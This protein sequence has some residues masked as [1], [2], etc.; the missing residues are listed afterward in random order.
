[1]DLPLQLNCKAPKQLLQIIL[2]TILEQKEWE[3]GLHSLQT[4]LK[5]VLD[6]PLQ[7]RTIAL[8]RVNK[9]PQLMYVSA[10]PHQSSLVWREDVSIQAIHWAKQITTYTDEL[11]VSLENSQRCVEILQ[12]LEVQAT[13]SGFL[14]FEFHDRAIAQWLKSLMCELIAPLN[15]IDNCSELNQPEFEKR[16]FSIQQAHARCCSL[17][18]LAHRENL[19]ESYLSDEPQDFLQQLPNLL[20]PEENVW[21]AENRRLWTDTLAER[22]LIYLLMTVLDEFVELS[23]FAAKQGLNLAANV[24]QSFQTAHQTIPLFG[25]LITGSHD[26]LRAYLALLLATQRVLNQ[27]LSALGYAAPIE[28]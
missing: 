25:T 9:P 22:N 26:R 3:I 7:T 19:I 28:L 10:L 27:L 24:S 18:R 11:K 23:L 1:M 20:C 13:P 2:Q 21:L 15:P 4:S 8:K 5:G 6:H 17:L 12:G 14:Q 16:L